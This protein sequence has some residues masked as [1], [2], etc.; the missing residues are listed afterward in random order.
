MTA[1]QTYAIRLAG[2]LD[3]AKRIKGRLLAQLQHSND[4]RTLQ[5]L[6]AVMVLLRSIEKD[7]S[8]SMV[9]MLIE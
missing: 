5:E 8:F 2:K 4:A 9:D 6:G 7:L 3:A 1:T